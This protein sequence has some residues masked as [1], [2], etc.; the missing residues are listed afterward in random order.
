MF[1]H[2]VSEFEYMNFNC[3]RLWLNIFKNLS[4]ILILLIYHGQNCK[5]QI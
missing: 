2:S 3:I 4:G 5:I 1:M